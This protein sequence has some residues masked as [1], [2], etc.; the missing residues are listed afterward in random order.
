MRYR[1][2]VVVTG[3]L[4]GPS[5]EHVRAQA[6]MGVSVTG[7]LLQSKFEMDVQIRPL[8]GQPTDGKRPITLEH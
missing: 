7:R 5:E 6:L 2:A 8:E 1:Y 3:E 4:E